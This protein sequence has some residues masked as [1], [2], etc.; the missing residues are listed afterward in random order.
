MGFIEREMDYPDD[1]CYPFLVFVDDEWE[2]H[3][4]MPVLG[5][6]KNSTGKSV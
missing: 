6:S 2:V 1:A 3:K 4:H 5:M